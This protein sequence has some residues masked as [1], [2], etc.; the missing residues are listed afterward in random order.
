MRVVCISDTHNKHNKLILP[1]G[2]CLIH[3]GDFSAIGRHH[4]VEHF[5]KWFSKQDF[6]Y[7]VFIAGN[8]DLSFQDELSWKRKI[9]KQYIHSENNP[10]HI[11]Y[12]QHKSITLEGVKIFG[13]PWSPE[14]GNWAFGYKRE[15][16]DKY[17]KKIP[18]DIDILITHGPPKDIL[19]ECFYN[20]PPYPKN[21]GC[22]Y[23]LTHILQI[24]P[25]LHIF[26]HI[27]EEYGIRQIAGFKTF[28]ANVSSCNL[29]YELVNQPTVF[30]L[31]KI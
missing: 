13:S 19:D 8:H 10:S 25:K 16:A 11:Y 7:K 1:P 14:F 23:L 22:N 4:E 24:Q 29:F 18:K 26:G 5:L 3:A 12:L 21:A 6:K 9:L 17:W 2:D 20:Q 30:D 31:D 15:L 28:F 27:H